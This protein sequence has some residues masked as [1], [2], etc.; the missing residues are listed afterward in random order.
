MKNPGVHSI[1]VLE[2]DKQNGRLLRAT[3]VENG[4]RVIL[5]TTGS[6]SIA[7]CRSNPPDLVICDVDDVDGDP[8]ALVDHLRSG[9]TCP[10][11]VLSGGAKESDVVGFLEGGADDYIVKPFR[12]GELIARSRAALRR[13]SAAEED[14]PLALGSLTVDFRSRTVWQRD[15]PVK[16]TPTEYALLH[17]LIRNAGKIL[18]H[19]YMLEQIW[20]G[21]HVQETEY[22]RVYIGH[23]RAKLGDDRTRSGF[24]ITASGIGYGFCPDPS[25]WR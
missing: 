12:R 2:S 20:G 7:R 25:S 11:I 23:L 15:E 1:L 10:V 16:L 4:F 22:L 14:S 3:L 24:I 5:A 6:E 13:R 9:G 19:R 18:T 17:L 21:E 8:F